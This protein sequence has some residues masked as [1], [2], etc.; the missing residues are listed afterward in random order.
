[1]QKSGPARAVGVHCHL[2]RGKYPFSRRNCGICVK[3][4]TF[5]QA[6]SSSLDPNNGRFDK[7]PSKA[8]HIF[9]CQ[10]CGLRRTYLID[11]GFHN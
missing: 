6:L 10:E 4:Q 5:L 1:M 2:Q 9:E 8:R 7:D 3:K 11:Y